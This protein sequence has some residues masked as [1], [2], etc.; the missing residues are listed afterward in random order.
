MNQL[1]KHV[2]HNLEHYQ[3]A[4]QQLRQEQSLNMEK[5]RNE[6]EQR[7]SQLQHQIASMTAEKSSYQAQY[8]QA[9]QI[10]EKLQLKHEL[11]NQAAHETQTKYHILSQEH[12]KLTKQYQG[13]SLDLEVKKQSIIET[14]VKLAA[15]DEKITILE[16][17]LAKADDKIQT[18]R[19]DFSFIS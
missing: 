13:Q 9:Q 6:Y 1:L 11:L 15:Y 17:S 7:I 14:K 19:D 5:Q 2:Q 18:L 16:K 8:E 3:T 10:L 4:T 12:V